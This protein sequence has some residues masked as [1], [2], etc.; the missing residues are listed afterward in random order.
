MKP[1]A[2]KRPSCALV[3]AGPG[4]PELLTL[5]ALRTLRRATVLLVDDLVVSGRTLQRAAVALRHAGARKVIAFAAH[6][7]FSDE[8]A[9]ALLDDAIAEIVVCDAVPA[10]PPGTPGPWQALQR[11]LRVVSCAP[12]FADAMRR[13]HEGWRR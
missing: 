1:R 10:P 13:A 11:K 6:G 2:A 4:D 8:A 12:L 9:G 5:K 7:L 3:G